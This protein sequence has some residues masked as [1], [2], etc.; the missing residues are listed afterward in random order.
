MLLSKYPKLRYLGWWNCIVPV[1]RWSAVAYLAEHSSPTTTAPSPALL[2]RYGTTEQVCELTCA[3]PP[4]LLISYCETV[5][6]L[7]KRKKCGDPTGTMTTT[8][9]KVKIVH[10]D[11]RCHNSTARPIFLASLLILKVT[12]DNSDAETRK[13]VVAPGK[14]LHGRQSGLSSLARPRERVIPGVSGTNILLQQSG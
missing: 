14:M 2:A 4:K 1:V 9:C 7:F 13:E 5:E 3:Y 11:K 10:L 8:H 6:S 12:A